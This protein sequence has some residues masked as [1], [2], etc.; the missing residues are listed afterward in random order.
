MSSIRTFFAAA[1]LVA[2]AA[3]TVVS[4]A[5]ATPV[6]R[7]TYGNWAV[8][9]DVRGGVIQSIRAYTSRGAASWLILEFAPGSYEPAIVLRSSPGDWFEAAGYRNRGHRISIALVTERNTHV[10]NNVEL[11]ENGLNDFL[12]SGERLDKLQAL[13]VLRRDRN[14][15]IYVFAES[16]R[17]SQT[18]IGR[19]DF[20]LTGSLRA[21]N[22]AEELATGGVG[23]I[24]PR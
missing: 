9:Q 13:E 20:S 10:F 8:D 19:Y 24:E 2:V 22:R 18:T 16:A 23:L 21:L 14:V 5:N 7:E 3:V 11:L 1:S 15:Q 4:N 17:G 12:L 6:A